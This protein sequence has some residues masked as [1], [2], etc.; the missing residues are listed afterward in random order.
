MKSG[1]I[2]QSST[3]LRIYTTFIMLEPK[4]SNLRTSVKPCFFSV[5]SL[6][7]TG[8]YWSDSSEGMSVVDFSVT[9]SL[10]MTR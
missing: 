2:V 3:L 1:N 6:S 7:P 8:T 10:G 5:T 9:M 4:L